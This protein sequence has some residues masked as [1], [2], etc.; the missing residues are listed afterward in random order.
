MSKMKNDKSSKIQQRNA[1]PVLRTRNFFA[2]GNE[3]SFGK[4]L[5]NLIWK[6]NNK[7]STRNPLIANSIGHYKASLMFARRLD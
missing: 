2:Y 6:R 7:T 4:C 3:Q 1:I 5:R